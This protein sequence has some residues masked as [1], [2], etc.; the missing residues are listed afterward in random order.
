MLRRT[1]E[2]GQKQLLSGLE[3]G[4]EMKSM[5][6]KIFG[7][8]L[9]T[10][11]SRRFHMGKLRIRSARRLCLVALSLAVVGAC[12]TIPFVIDT[13]ARAPVLDGFGD[14]TLVP[15]QGNEAARRL[16]AQGMT[17]TY[18]FNRPEA[19]RAFKA[20]LAADP[21]CA[22]CAWGVG[23]QMGPNINGRSRGDLR[24]AVKYIDY[25]VKHS[26]G[27]SERD[28]ALIQ[29]AALRYGHSS[30]NNLAPPADAICRTT[31]E[32]EPADPLDIVYAMHMHQL[33]ERFPNDP[34]VLTHYA[35]AEM[36]ATR[37]PGWD[38]VTGKPAGRIGDMAAKIEKALTTHP[39]H[40][41]L[42]HYLIHALDA[43]PVAS[44]AVAAAD[45]LGR[46]APKS[47]HLLHMPSHTYGHVGRYADATRVNQLAVAAD[48]AMMTELKKQQFKETVDWRD[49]NTHFQWYGA[50]MEGR[51]DLALESARSASA[52]T[53]GDDE[54]SEYM[55][56][57][58]LL[59]LLHL[60]RWDALA[61]EPLAKGDKGVAMALSEMAR[62]IGQVRTGKRSEAAATL[63]RIEARNKSLF[64]KHKGNDFM[65]KLVRGLATS[66]Q[67]QLAAEIAFVDGRIDE[68]LKLQG[69]AVEA[70]KLPNQTEPPMLASGPRQRLGSMQLRVKRFKEAEQ[71]FL[72]DL[73]LHPKNGWALAGLEKSLVAQGKETDAQKARREL[74]TSWVAADSSVRGIQ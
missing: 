36:V 43:V 66:S 42:N 69:E 1:A 49:H 71:S 25:A 55:R 6:F 65:A 47:P 41:G 56:T 67:T 62:G 18:A 70:G 15:S 33:A 38:P 21:E 46:L 44:R 4:S 22:M 52:R 61:A 37:G 39:D 72:A 51:G 58:P 9:P 59:T 60:Q 8:L 7:T 14:A 32:E 19:I 24:E 31:G 53:Q 73:A 63:A 50:L 28:Q 16:F 29:A 30:A 34:D 2:F 64:E 26:R 27:A 74:A 45:K 35:E 11:F 20:A 23:L 3:S 17:Q 13:N 5:E 12:T 48:E 10:T 54:W 68:A 57:L 40:V